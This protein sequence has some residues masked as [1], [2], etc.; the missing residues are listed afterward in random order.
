MALNVGGWLNGLRTIDRLLDLEAKHGGLINDQR[1]RV[2]ELA[3]RVTRLEAREAVMIAEAKGAAS[4]AAS[5]VAAQQ[6]GDL[7]RHV[8]G[9]DERVRRL[10]RGDLR[11]PPAERP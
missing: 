6:L 10:E 9:L 7:A 8:G 5:V 11:L 1:R 3:E 4:S 2:D